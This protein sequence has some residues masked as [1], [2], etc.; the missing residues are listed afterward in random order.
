[1]PDYLAMILGTTIGSLPLLVSVTVYLPQLQRQSSPWI[2]LRF[3]V[4]SG[5]WGLV[6]SGASTLVVLTTPGRVMTSIFTS[7]SFAASALSFL[8]GP[9][10]RT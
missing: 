5:V 3:G 9:L 2:P 7:S 1:M 10:G 6:D 8:C 4:A